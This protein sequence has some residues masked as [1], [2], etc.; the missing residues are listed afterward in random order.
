M[1]NRYR[2]T[3]AVYE[4]EAEEDKIVPEKIIFLSVEGNRTE[5]DY[6]AG[7]SKN[8]EKLGIN[9]KIDVEVLHR[10]SWDTSSAPDQVLELLEEYIRLREQD[11][12]GMLEEISR[13]F[14]DTYP[15]EFI[16]QYLTAPEMIPRKQRSAFETELKTIGY[17]IKYRKYLKKYNSKL[18]EF[19]VLIDRDM[20]NHHQ[21]DMQ[22]CVRHCRQHRYKCYIANP[23]FEFWLLLHLSEIRK[24]YGAHLE[25]I[26]ENKKVSKRH[27]FVSREVSKK[28]RHG[29]SGIHFAETYLPNV[30]YA[31]TQAK[32][33]ASEEEELV[34]QIGCNL[35]KMIEEMQT[36]GNGQKPKTQNGDKYE[37]NQCT[38]P[39]LQRRGKCRGHQPGRGGDFDP[40]SAQ[41]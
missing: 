1:T 26:R 19:A 28:A 8:R 18:D 16:R 41:V 24:E 32:G 30:G 29:K 33:F 10:G 40:G 27:T 34:Q 9:G 13:E 25:D 7:I 4:R 37:E 15:V 3:S 35:W 22:K 11:E 17:D 39:L 38:D 6:F 14:C 21:T 12:D 23:C 31:V 20:Q 5:K 2:L 36:Y